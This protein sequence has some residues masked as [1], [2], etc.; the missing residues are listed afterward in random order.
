MEGLFAPPRSFTL[1]IKRREGVK[2]EHFFN[3]AE[4]LKVGA[5]ALMK[6]YPST[7]NRFF[8]FFLLSSLSDGQACQERNVILGH[9][10]YPA[11]H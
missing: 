4:T 3:A 2:R 7:E 5:A 6:H 9:S 1:F 10:V 11:T 8:S